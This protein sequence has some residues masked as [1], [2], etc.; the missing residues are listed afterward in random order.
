MAS[1][2]GGR[3]TG[4]RREKKIVASGFVV[5]LIAHT[6]E[7]TFS[8]PK[9]PTQLTNQSP[10]FKGHPLLPP[11]SSC[12]AE[13]GKIGVRG[14]PPD[15]LEAETGPD[16]LVFMLHVLFYS[17]SAHP[18]MAAIVIGRSMSMSSYQ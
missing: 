15:G 17:S 3:T 10:V 2:S 7:S 12:G 13:I 11:S 6:W 14:G 9:P 16:R 1:S 8:P 4:V 5:K 18:P